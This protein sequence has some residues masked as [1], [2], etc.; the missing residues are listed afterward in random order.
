MRPRAGRP[1]R[2]YGDLGIG[3]DG[4]GRQQR[5]ASPERGRRSSRS[6][7]AGGSE[8]WV[9]DAAG[10]SRRSS[11]ERGGPPPTVF[12]A[13]QTGSGE[14]A[15]KD[16]LRLLVGADRP[17]DR[18]PRKEAVPDA[19]ARARRYHTPP[20]AL[21][22]GDDMAATLW[23]GLGAP[24][25]EIRREPVYAGGPPQRPCCSRQAS[26]RLRSW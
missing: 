24:P 16:S 26:R 19:A 13:F 6:A 10:S 14:T 1:P 15:P 9:L 23:T 8:K 21:M 20:S 2:A 25:S 7:G 3:T 11:E 17:G 4:A 12:E 22:S 18:Q 5:G